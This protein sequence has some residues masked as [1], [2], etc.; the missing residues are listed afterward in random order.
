MKRRPHPTARGRLRGVTLLE[1]M[2]SLAL[3]L[4]VVGAITAVYLAASRNLHQQDAEGRLQSVG[5]TALAML[6]RQ[7][8]K[9]GMVDMP[10]HWP[11]WQD[12]V[13]GADNFDYL[14]RNA[15]A[16]A[17]AALPTALSGCDQGYSKSSG[18]TS[19]AGSA[20]KTCNGG[21]THPGA[22]TLAWQVSR[23][24]P[25]V[26]DTV[27]IPGCLGGTSG[28][29]S[30]AVPHLAYVDAT[31]A[32][33][34]VLASMT[35]CRISIAAGADK[36][37]FNEDGGIASTVAENVSDLRF[38][39]LVAAPGDSSR[40]QAYQSASDLDAGGATTWADVTGVEVCLLARVPLPGVGVASRSHAGCQVDASGL[41]IVETTNDNHLYRAFR[42][43]VV[44]R[45]RV[46]ASVSAY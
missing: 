30:L 42:Q 44:L 38:R 43:V 45:S 19:G 16:S 2:V 34:D 18:G 40:L 4:L 5:D 7:I 25:A 32:T 22:L 11:G 37:Q 14:M 36:L 46:Q 8:Q 23:T 39:F 3:G 13:P 31:G 28:L 1:L 17:G 33:V 27:V 9:A 15:S 12:V 26:D 41:P 6:A 29:A 21:G 20:S 24:G 10:A 35:T